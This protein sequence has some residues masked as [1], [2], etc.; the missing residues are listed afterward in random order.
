MKLQD[1]FKIYPTTA[2]VVL[3][4]SNNNDRLIVPADMD[5]NSKFIRSSKRRLDEEFFMDGIIQDDVIIHTSN[6][7]TLVHETCDGYVFRTHVKDKCDYFLFVILNEK[8]RMLE[9]LRK[10]SYKSIKTE[11]DRQLTLNSIT[12][13]NADREMSVCG[14]YV[15]GE[16]YF[17]ATSPLFVDKETYQSP[18]VPYTSTHDYIGQYMGVCYALKIALKYADR[19]DKVKI[20]ADKSLRYAD[21]VYKLPLKQ[22]RP[23][24]AECKAYADTMLQLKD[25][26]SK[27]GVSIC[28]MK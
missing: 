20:Y 16:Y 14:G 12:K 5:I 27:K 4:F 25:E 13:P 2:Q 26:L 18:L 21:G 17:S 8:Y 24:N 28:F 23:F 7:G 3:K 1:L 6:T 11:S 19:L 9:N 22:W 10:K 15:D